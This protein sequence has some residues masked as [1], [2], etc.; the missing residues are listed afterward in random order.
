M[1]N[2]AEHLFTGLFAIHLYLLVNYLFKP[3]IHLNIFKKLFSFLK[4]FIYCGYKFLIRL[5]ICKYHL[6]VIWKYYL[7]TCGSSFHFLKI[8]FEEE[9]ILVL[10]KSIVPTFTFWIVVLIL[11]LRILCLTQNHKDFLLSFFLKFL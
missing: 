7:M 1:T 10:V 3:F 8:F 5:V 9:N 11:H 2:D 4:L 6:F